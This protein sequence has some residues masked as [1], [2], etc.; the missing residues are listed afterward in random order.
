[1]QSSKKN[2]YVASV[3]SSSSAHDKME[4]G[5]RQKLEKM[6]K[7]GHMLLR[8]NDINCIGKVK[9]RGVLCRGRVAGNGCYLFSRGI[10]KSD[11]K[12]CHSNKRIDRTKIVPSTPRSLHRSTRTS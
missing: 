2:M 7:K 3:K 11:S 6:V 5:D 9:A 10:N 12:F 4:S 8:C 1:M